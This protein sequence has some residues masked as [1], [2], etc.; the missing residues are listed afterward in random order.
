MT[1]RTEK[2]LALVALA[3]AIGF[4]A[5]VLAN[6]GSALAKSKESPRAALE[7]TRCE[8]GKG[9]DDITSSNMTNNY[10]PVLYRVI[11][12]ETGHRWWVVDRGSYA[13]MVLDCGG[14]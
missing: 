12:K 2:A 6:A 14:E 3:I 8:L 1:M 11:D 9:M 13:P 10:R 7:W 5:G 4:L